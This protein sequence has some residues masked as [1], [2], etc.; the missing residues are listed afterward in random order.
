M[1]EGLWHRVLKTKYLRFV[2]V[3]RWFCTGNISEVK[4]S[5]S[6]IYLIKSFHVLMHLIA[7]SPGSGHSILIDK[8]CVIGMGLSTILSDEL[9]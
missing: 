3:E 7:W 9:I 4:G 5:H 1:H 8:Y 2:F 6:W